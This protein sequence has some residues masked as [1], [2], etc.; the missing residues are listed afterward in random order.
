MSAA[1]HPLRA[2]RPPRAQEAAGDEE[3]VKEMIKLLADTRDHLA[4]VPTHGELEDISTRDE[5]LLGQA[6]SPAALQRVPSTPRRYSDA[7]ARI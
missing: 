2:A 4:T 6:R 3:K 5:K 1:A 7:L